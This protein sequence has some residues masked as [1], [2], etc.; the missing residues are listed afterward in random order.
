MSV[1]TIGDAVGVGVSVGMIG[2]GVGVGV[3]GVG[4]EGVGVGVIVDSVTSS[5][6][7]IV[8][9]FSSGSLF[10]M[11]RFPLYTPNAKFALRRTVT[12]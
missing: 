3:N 10:E 2:D 1:D 6:T 12:F 7:G 11:M 5:F 9:G 4:L 8:T